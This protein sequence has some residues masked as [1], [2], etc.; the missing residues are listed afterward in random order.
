MQEEIDILLSAPI[1]LNHLLIPLMLKQPQQGVVVNVT[2][3]GAYIPQVFA[4]IYSACKAALYSYTITLRH[5]LTGTNCRVTELIPP[6]VQTGLAGLG[7]NHGADLDE[8]CDAV[9]D[10]LTTTG[11]IQIGF[12]PTKDLVQ[13]I[14]GQPL[15]ER[16]EAGLARFP[17]NTYSKKD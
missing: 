3:G 17:V 16:F 6:A 5:S 13:Q 4:P 9:F 12:G 8:F 1:H 10:K 15:T 2:S 11:D 7:L 14:N